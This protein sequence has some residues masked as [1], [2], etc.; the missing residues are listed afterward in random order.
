[1]DVLGH[2]ELSSD[3]FLTRE[4]HDEVLVAR[5]ALPDGRAETED[6]QDVLVVLREKEE[7]RNAAEEDLVVVGLATQPQKVGEHIHIVTATRRQHEH[8]LEAQDH[9]ASK[10][11]NVR[12][13]LDCLMECLRRTNVIVVVAS[14]GIGAS[15]RALG[16]MRRS[17][18]VEADFDHLV[19][20][21]LAFGQVGKLKGDFSAASDVGVGDIV[22]RK[23]KS[24]LVGNEEGEVLACL[25]VRGQHQTKTGS[26]PR[27]SATPQFQPLKDVSCVSSVMPKWFLSSSATLSCSCMGLESSAG[28]HA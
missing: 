8:F 24:G 13:V 23:F 28:K 7:A 18:D 25:E 26:A 10:L 12:S 19:A 22:E 21:D 16:F 20:G 3:L 1:V 11:P 5:L 27:K 14:L 2:I 17:G 4:L 9:I 15:V 6:E